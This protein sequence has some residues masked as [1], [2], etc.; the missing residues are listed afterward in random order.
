M[1]KELIAE[2]ETLIGGMGN[3]VPRD[4]TI[5]CKRFFSGAAAYANGRIFISLTPVGL[6]VKLAE[7]DKEALMQ[8]GGNGA[9]IFPEGAGQEGLCGCARKSGRQHGFTQTLA[10]SVYLL[11]VDLAQTEKEEAQ[12]NAD[13]RVVSRHHYCLHIF[14]DFPRALN[15]Q[16][17]KNP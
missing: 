3:A 6:A 5:Y 8:M 16:L 13:R 14:S 12:K 10:G 4:A 11:C 9:P 2:L 15:T 1:T 7:P 17:K